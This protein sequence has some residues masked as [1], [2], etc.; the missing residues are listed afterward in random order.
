MAFIEN[1]IYCMP[2]DRG[3][4]EVVEAK[5]DKNFIDDDSGMEITIPKG[6]KHCFC[7]KC[8]RAWVIF[9]TQFEKPQ[10]FVD[11]EDKLRNL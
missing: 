2:Y 1:C 5:E 9:G 6:K 4:V 10:W 3:N 8:Y 11:I 7:R